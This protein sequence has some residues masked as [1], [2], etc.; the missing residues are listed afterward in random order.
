MHFGTTI[1]PLLCR[2]AYAGGTVVTVGVGVAGESVDA[3]RGGG[4]W[5]EEVVGGKG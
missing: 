3:G 2:A 5:G 1:V 4:A